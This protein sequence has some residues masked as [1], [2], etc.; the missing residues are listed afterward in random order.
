MDPFLSMHPH[1]EISARLKQNLL[2]SRNMQQALHIL[3]L[4]ILEI[5]EMVNEALLTNPL[6]HFFEKKEY[7]SLYF[8]AL[9]EQKE[10]AYQMLLLQ[11]KELR[12][13]E[14]YRLCKHMLGYVDAQGYLKE[15]INELQEALNC[16]K[17]KVE[18]LK[19][20]IKSFDPPGVGAESLQEAYL[21]QLERKGQKK[22]TAYQIIAEHF[23]KLVTNQLPE[24]AKKLHIPLKKVQSALKEIALLHMHPLKEHFSQNILAIKPDVTVLEEKGELK[25]EVKES[26]YRNLR[27][28]QKYLDLMQSI[29]STKVEKTYL[30]SKFQAL[31]WLMHNLDERNRTLYRITEI[32][33]QR[34][35]TFFKEKK[36]NPLTRKEIANE[37]AL[38]ES[39]ITRACSNK[40][41]DTPSGLYPFSFFFSG[42]YRGV[43]Q[44]HSKK[45]LLKK[46]E[47]IIEG[48][49]KESPFSDREIGDKLLEAGVFCARRT[50]TKMRQELKIGT[51]AQRRQYL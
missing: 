45:E 43:S 19:S 26:F 22:S 24:I 41:M 38:A 32:I 47:T 21:L 18:E 25:I 4:P 42:S 44:V 16:S 48:E 46:L 14:D 7:K 8:E 1:V 33:L 37:L 51:K 17:D 49:K 40:W 35:K 27:L 5:E 11:A 12:D 34:Q 10:T 6:V 36:L 20:F 30:F 28:N 2:L 9:M 15:D 31:K 13:R 3:Q 39:T 29:Y 23:E 50:V